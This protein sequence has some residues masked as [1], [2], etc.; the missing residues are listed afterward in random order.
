MHVVF[1]NQYFPPDVAPTG[2]LVRKVA[3]E[4]VAMGHEVTVICGTGGYGGGSQAGENPEEGH[5]RLHVRRMSAT[6]FGRNHAAG[7]VL[8]YL[9]FY[10]LA[11]IDLLRM[12]KPDVVVC[13]TTPPYLSVLG[14]IGSFLRGARHSH[15]VM[16]L[17]PDVL[18]A[19]GAFKRPLR[20]HTLLRMLAKLGWGGGRNIGVLTLGPDM[21]DRTA[22]YVPASVLQTWIP[23]W[24]TAEENA[25]PAPDSVARLREKRRWQPGDVILMYSGNMGLGHRFQELLGSAAGL[26]GNVKLV[27]F[28]R[29][30]RRPE[31]EAFQSQ[32]PT[33]VELHDYVNSQ[34]LA[35]HLRSGDVHL[36]S[37][38]PS[39]DGTMVPSKLQGIFAAGR[40]VIFIGS[41]T[42]ST[43][44]WIHESGAGWIVAP[45]DNGALA[46]AIKEAT[47]PGERQR[48]GRLASDYAA[49]HFG[50]SANARAS[51][52]FLIGQMED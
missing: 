46:A 16:D 4:I 8:D 12:N 17:Y 27:F 29:G 20:G 38:E 11:G 48:K 13:M 37:L 19:H 10:V 42:S 22:K 36:V 45:G 25:D 3:E 1:I 33:M 2:V 43:G 14:R 9:S 49:C 40:P 21:R 52:R 6:R 50:A 41:A 35:A 15:W 23:L 7:K 26:P 18:D 32:H 39:W 24:G 44:Q 28:G 47:D 30:K 5:E 51:A 34:D 31:I